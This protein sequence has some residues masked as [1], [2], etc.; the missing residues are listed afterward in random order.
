MRRIQKVI[1][2]PKAGILRAK[3]LEE[4]KEEENL[5]VLT[6]F[7]ERNIGKYYKTVVG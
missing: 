1:N 3:Q 7:K 6:R 4:F 5:R 2:R